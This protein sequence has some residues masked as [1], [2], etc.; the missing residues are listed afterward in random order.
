M[1]T[2]I[3][4]IPTMQRVL[5]RL[6]ISRKKTLRASARD[7]IARLIWLEII[8]AFNLKDVVFVDETGTHTAFTRLYARA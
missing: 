7:E 6:D 4:L 2:Y 3:G 1:T 5:N 8:G